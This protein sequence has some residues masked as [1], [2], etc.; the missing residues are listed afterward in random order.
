MIVN[1]IKTAADIEKQEIPA[2]APELTTHAC[3]SVMDIATLSG[4]SPRIFADCLTI[5]RFVES[6]GSMA[7]W[8]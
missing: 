5:V 4:N 2:F 3:F 1:G 6:L 8:E 7:T